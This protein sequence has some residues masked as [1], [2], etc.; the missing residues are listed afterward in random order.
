MIVNNSFKV[1][2][3]A[4][5]RRVAISLLIIAW[6]GIPWRWEALHRRRRI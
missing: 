1:I 3:L 4:L 5:W 6:R 2:L